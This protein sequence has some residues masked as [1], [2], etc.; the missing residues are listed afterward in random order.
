MRF[1]FC[2]LSLFDFTWGEE[3]LLSEMSLNYKLKKL[4]SFWNIRLT[5]KDF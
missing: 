1:F 5:A 4:L 3:L 2:G